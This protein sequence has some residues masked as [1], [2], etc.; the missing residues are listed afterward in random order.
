[1]DWA[2]MMVFDAAGPSYFAYSHEGVLDDG[3]RGKPS[4]GRDLCRKKSLYAALSYLLLNARLQRLYSSRAIAEHMMWHATHQTE[5]GSMCHPSDAEAWKHFDRIYP[6]FAE[7][8]RNVQLGLRIE[9]FAP[10]G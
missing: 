4:R 1:M 7:E 9:S 6:N 5:E 2:Q 10:H 8:P 3:T